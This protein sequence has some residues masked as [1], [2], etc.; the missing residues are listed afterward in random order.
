MHVGLNDGHSDPVHWPLRNWPGWQL[1]SVVHAAHMVLLVAVA[2]AVTYC[3]FEQDET[4]L[5]EI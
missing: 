2:R 5:Q 3:V 1:D 4:L